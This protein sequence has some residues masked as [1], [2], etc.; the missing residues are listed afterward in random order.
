LRNGTIYAIDPFD[1]SGDEG[2]ATMYRELK[3]NTNLVDQFK[4]NLGEYIVRGTVQVRQGLSRD[5]VGSFPSIDMLF[6][7]GSHALED[8]L[9]DFESYSPAVKDGGVVMFHDY[10]RDREDLGPNWVVRNQL[11]G[12][13]SWQFLG[14][15]GSLIA[16]KKTARR[17]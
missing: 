5:F 8:C 9:F 2:S 16:F 13:K 14:Q 1:A 12:S 11:L 7:D 6:I 17:T 10:Y 3:G 4:A 15:H